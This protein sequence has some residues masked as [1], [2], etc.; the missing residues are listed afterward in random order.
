MFFRSNQSIGEEELEMGWRR[1]GGTITWLIGDFRIVHRC[2]GLSI[3]MIIIID[4]RGQARLSAIS[5]RR[6]QVRNLCLKA[7]DTVS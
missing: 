7:R 3:F 6:S 5:G 1:S 4:W 2:I